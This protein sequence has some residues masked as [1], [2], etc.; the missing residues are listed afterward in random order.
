MNSTEPLYER[1]RPRTLDEVAGQSHL[2]G[3]N[4]L[5][6]SLLQ[7]LQRGL[8]E[9]IP[10]MI[11]WGPPG[12]GKTTLARLIAN[13][14]GVHMEQLSATSSG[15]KDLRELIEQG[16]VRVA[17]ERKRLLVFVDEIHRFN[18]SQ[19]DALLPA[20]EEGSVTLIGATTENPSFSLNRALLSRTRVFELKP[21]EDQELLKLLERCVADASRG[22]GEYDWDFEEGTKELLIRLAGGD[23]RSLLNALEWLSLKGHF[24]VTKEHVMEAL[25]ASPGG[26][27]QSGDDRYLL[28]S[29][30][31]KSIRHSDAQ[32]SLYYLARMLE[33]GEDPLYL[34]RR[35]LRVASEDV[36]LADPAALTQA[37]AAKEAVQLM[38]LPEAELALAQATVYLALAPKSNALYTA[39]AA[40][41]K[42]VFDKGPLQVPLHLRNA[43]NSFLKKMGYGEGYKYDHDAPD[44]VARG[45]A[46]PPELKGAE[47]YKPKD[48]AFERELK[49]RME[50]FRIRQAAK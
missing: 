35:L 31:H 4:K 15:V 8:L 7:S 37:H 9:V 50:Y 24:Q 19:Q 40:A 1:M 17:L 29:A 20:I 26:Y 6:G 21:L 22:V 47:F 42:A 14:M 12:T 28:I 25:Q 44:S 30:L 48:R 2:I 41:K 33:A 45:E 10:S 23:A 11:F 18:K 27:D 38:G 5:L 43:S 34:A 49:K 32:A 46:L 39:Y 3:E 13:S 16:R 36:G